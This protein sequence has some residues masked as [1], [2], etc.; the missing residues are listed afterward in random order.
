MEYYEKYLKSPW[1]FDAFT[2]PLINKLVFNIKRSPEYRDI[3]LNLLSD[4]KS[5]SIDD[6]IKDEKYEKMP[7]FFSKKEWTSENYPSIEQEYKSELNKMKIWS[8]KPTLYKR[9]TS[10]LGKEL[11]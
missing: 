3:L 4:I 7:W 5:K 2:A 10:R 8:T 6:I 1:E 11:V 9:F